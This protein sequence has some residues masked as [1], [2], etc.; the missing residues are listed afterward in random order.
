M[1]AKL[2]GATGPIE[3]LLPG[4]EKWKTIG[5]SKQYNFV[6]GARIRTGER[7]LC[8]LESAD[9]GKFRLNESA[10]IV[11]LDSNQVKL[12]SGK[13]WCASPKTTSI[14]VDTAFEDSSVAT[15]RC[16]SDSQFQCV[17]QPAKS[18]CS[19]I[20]KTNGLASCAVGALKRNVDP[21]QTITI[22]SAAK[23]QPMDLEAD[24]LAKSL[25]WQLP[26]LALGSSGGNELHASLSQVLA[27]IG[28]TKARHMNEQQIRLLGP[29]G[30]VPLL[31]FATD[32]SSAN[33]IE[34]RRTAVRI[35]SDL[36]DARS[37]K[38]LTELKTD[39]DVGIAAYSTRALERIANEDVR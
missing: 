12:Q 11:F 30:A 18:T 2:I 4:E 35:A 32:S 39:S 21:G 13:L 34:L 38:W 15:F 25:V 26:L 22:D 17:A 31:V 1:V 14:R 28:M 9:H 33:Q 27:P 37:I 19:S 6:A 3:I 24:Q 29:R 23:K 5:P 20:A 8:E 7:V 16:P 10:E 36:A